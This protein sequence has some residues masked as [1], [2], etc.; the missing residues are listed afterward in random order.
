MKLFGLWQDRKAWKEAQRLHQLEHDTDQPTSL[1][2]SAVAH[3]P[4]ID[5]YL[6]VFDADAR[7]KFQEAGG[8]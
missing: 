4:N 8:Q 5:E 6:I 7:R 3:L 1:P 2:C